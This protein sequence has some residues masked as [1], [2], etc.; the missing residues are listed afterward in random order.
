MNQIE[1]EKD[2]SALLIM[3]MQNAFVHPQGSLA[4]MGLDTSR[5]YHAVEPIRQLREAFK[6]KKRPIIYLQ[7]NHHTN[8]SEAIL[9]SKVFPS[10]KKTKHCIEGTWDSEFIKDIVPEPNNYVINKNDSANYQKQLQELLKDLDIKSLVVTGVST[11]ICEETPL[12][13]AF[14]N[15]LDVFV[16]EEATVSYTLAEEKGSIANFDVAYGHTVKVKDVLYE[17]LMLVI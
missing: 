9:I 11:N 6:A 13:D 8:D 15:G 5:A 4:K 17:M 10:I 2:H 14:G 16:P 12:S 7:H 1:F 3:D